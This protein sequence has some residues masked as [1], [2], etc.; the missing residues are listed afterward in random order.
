ML[1]RHNLLAQTALIFLLLVPS[2]A[3]AVCEVTG[4]T[5]TLSWDPTF[6]ASGYTIYYAP[7]PEADYV[8]SIDVG[9]RTTVTFDVWEGAAFYLAVQAYNEKETS[10]LSNIE[11]FVVVPN[12]L[13]TAPD[14]DIRANGSG[15][16]TFASTKFPVSISVDLD[17][18]D[19]A[20]QR[21]DSWIVARTPFGWFSYV[22]ASGWI[23][24]IHRYTEATIGFNRSVEVIDSPLPPGDYLFQ[25]ALDDND[26]GVLDGTWSD[27]VVVQVWE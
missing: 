15:V 13:S 19:Q 22:D 10:D 26:D 21:R 12:P 14:L 24:G 27:S 7:Y 2:V 17:P 23:P 5:V 25:V 20:L 6:G 3:L 9:N 1:N 18:G 8:G 16:E 11:T 4:P